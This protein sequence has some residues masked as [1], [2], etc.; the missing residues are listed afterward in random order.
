MYRGIPPVY[1]AGITG[2]GH[3]DKFGTTSIPL[4]DTSEVRYDMDTGTAGTGT[5]FHRYQTLRYLRYNMNTGTGHFDKFSTTSIP[6]PRIPVPHRTH[7]REFRSF[8]VVPPVCAAAMVC[9][10]GILLL[11]LL[12]TSYFPDLSARPGR[13][14]LEWVL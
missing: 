9:Q 3:F 10:Q 14:L 1:T 7:P 8:F 5:Y 11:R 2:T 12:Y 6:V 13:Y 4:P